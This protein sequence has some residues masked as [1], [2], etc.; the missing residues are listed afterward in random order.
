MFPARTTYI[1]FLLSLIWF[2]N[3]HLSTAIFNFHKREHPS[4]PT[5]PSVLE[6]ALD[7]RPQPSS[8]VL[9]G[10]LDDDGIPRRYRGEQ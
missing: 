9:G 4:L 2:M 10:G 6:I 3:K 5:S 7:E 8:S 1:P